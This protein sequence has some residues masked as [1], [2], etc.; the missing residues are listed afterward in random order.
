MLMY[1]SFFISCE[2]IYG[3]TKLR[4]DVHDR[5]ISTIHNCNW[6]LACAYCYGTKVLILCISLQGFLAR[7]NGIP[8]VELYRLAKKKDRRLVLCG[9]SL[10]GAVKWLCAF[11]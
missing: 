6:L 8:A 11:F 3:V 5:S 7:A 10:G 4:F 1:L 9:H 2:I